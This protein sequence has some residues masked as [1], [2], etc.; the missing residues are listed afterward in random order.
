MKT[1]KDFR[2]DVCLPD[3]FNGFPIDENNQLLVVPIDY[4]MDKKEIIDAIV[5]EYDAYGFQSELNCRLYDTAM[6]ELFQELY[7]S[8]D[9]QTINPF[10]IEYSEDDTVYL[11]FMIIFE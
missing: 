2:I 6:N 5:A 3:Y 9:L 1:V 4:S 7:N 8:G 10:D 11:Y